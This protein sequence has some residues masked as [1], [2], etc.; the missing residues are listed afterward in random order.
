MKSLML[1]PDR[2][3]DLSATK[4]LHFLALHHGGQNSWHRWEWRNYVTVNPYNI[5]MYMWWQIWRPYNLED[6][7]RRRVR[8]LQR[9][10][11]HLRPQGRPRWS[12]RS[13]PATGGQL[14]AVR[15]CWEPAATSC[16][17]WFPWRPGKRTAKLWRLRHSDYKFTGPTGERDETAETAM[18]STVLIYMS[19]CLS[20]C[21]SVYLPVRPSVCLSIYLYIYIY[22]FYLIDLHPIDDLSVALIKVQTY[23]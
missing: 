7:R 20:V 3:S 2:R 16:L 19:V 10:V 15:P 4:C 11:L 23:D 13:A 17:S 21:L 22:L 18:R 8:I 6:L 5:Y 9:W 1:S 14:P 12:P